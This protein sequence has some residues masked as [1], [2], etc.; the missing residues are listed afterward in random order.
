MATY[1]PSLA[2][3]HEFVQSLVWVLK[4]GII[5]GALLLI[6][7]VLLAR[8]TTWGRQYWRITGDYFRGRQ[9]VPV[10]GLFLVL[11]LSVMMNVRIEVLLSYYVNDVYSSLQVAFEGTAAGNTAVRNSGT[12]GFWMAIATFC[13]LASVNI[14]RF[15]LDVYLTQRFIIRW[16]V[17][18]THR[19]TGDWLQGA[20]FY[21]GR[22]IEHTIDNPDQRIQQDIDTF[23][24]G[25]GSM[26]RTTPPSTPA[27]RWCWAR[28][29]PSLQ[30][31]RSRPSSGICPARWSFSACRS[32]RRCS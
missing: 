4:A 12:H 25:A 17:W 7:A 29:D 16:R 27:T 9:S 10:W 11:L 14:V 5:S 22:F 30:R 1:T 6:V 15:V 24:A 13:V 23:T 26:R 21:R 32:R 31:S 28:R 2:W 8:Y 18:L 3:N 20:A 19:L